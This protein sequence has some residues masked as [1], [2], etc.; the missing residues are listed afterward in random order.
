MTMGAYIR[1]I[2]RSQEITLTIDNNIQKIVYIVEL[3]I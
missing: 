2:E 3:E 1:G